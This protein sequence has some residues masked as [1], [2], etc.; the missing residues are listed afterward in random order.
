ML[1]RPKFCANCGDAIERAQWFLWTSRRFCEVCEVELKGHEL[2]PRLVVGLL[3]LVASGVVI[4]SFS[5]R[6]RGSS[7]SARLITTAI[8]PAPR[9][10]PPE[11]RL[12]EEAPLAETAVS[13]QPATHLQASTTGRN[14]ISFAKP[15]VVE[16]PTR[17]CAA[18]TKKGT[19]CSRRVKGND[20]C[21]QHL[22]M[23][24]MNVE[25]KQIQGSRSIER[26]SSR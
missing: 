22:G 8:A 9:S 18:E 15:T 25:Q 5:A 4:T 3:L 11:K 14:P 19:P 17:I 6:S 12:A 10:A 16:E 20:R 2:M 24:A 23:P 26:T 7:E 1:Y 21:Y 13:G